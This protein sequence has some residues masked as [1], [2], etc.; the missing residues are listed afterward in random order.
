VW[1]SKKSHFLNSSE[2]FTTR[3][4]YF[5]LNIIPHTHKRSMREPMD[6]DPLLEKCMCVSVRLND[7]IFLK[8]YETKFKRLVRVIDFFVRGEPN[9][10]YFVS[11]RNV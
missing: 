3:K 7:I 10:L 9:F 6:D 2:F 11:M 8:T 5:C 1:E 4:N